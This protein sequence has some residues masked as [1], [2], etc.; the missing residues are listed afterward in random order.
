MQN[1]CHA[2]GI[3][4]RQMI[5]SNDEVSSALS[6]L[7]PVVALETTIFSNL[8]LP[9][10]ANEQALDRCMSAIR[11]LGAVPALTAV[12]DGRIWA[13]VPTELHQRVLSCGVKIAERDLSVATAQELAE[14][15]TTVSASLAIAERA[16]I[17][18]F[19]TGGIGGVHRSSA[20]TG[21]ISADLN[22]IARRNVLVVSAGAK[23]F[24]DLPRTL[25]FLETHS[26]PVLG[27]KTYDFPAFYTRNSGLRVGHRV[28]S[29]LEVAKIHQSRRALGQGG[30]LLAVPI[31]EDAELD[32]QSINAAIAESL[33]RVEQQKISGAQI[34][35]HV[36]AA[37]ETATEGQSVAAN[38][39]LAEN[40]ASIAARVA[41][42]LAAL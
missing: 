33:A 37:I 15:V 9:S 10:P 17:E 1:D 27:W 18:T 13:G 11:A 28:D 29:A 4:E 7:K 16:G 39:A 6:A 2:G 19:A 26:V 8:G 36:L 41:V 3:E 42:E 14:G 25:A 24:L 34:T 38:L 21:D 5:D 30:S 12:I 40:N 35:P 22:A 31:P 32:A 20:E 23:A